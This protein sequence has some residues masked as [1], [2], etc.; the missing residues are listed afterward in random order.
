MATSTTNPLSDRRIQAAHLLRRAGFGGTSQD[1]EQYAAMSHSDAVNKLLNFVPNPQSTFNLQRRM[2][3]VDYI[4]HLD[5]IQTW[6]VDTMLNTPNPLQEK[7]TLFWHGHFTSAYS[8]VDNPI[9]L[10]EQ[11]QLFRAN[12]LGNFKDLV[13]SV[14]R[15]PAMIYYLDGEAN[16]KNAPNE[17]YAR[18]LMELFT[19]GIGNYTETDVRE[20]A[21][22]FTGWGL[23]GRTF[24]FN[25]NNHDNGTKTFMGQTGN[26]NGDDIIDIILKQ[27]ASGKFIVTELWNYFVYPNPDPSVIS[28]LTQIYYNNNYELKPV[29]QAMLT[30]PEFLSAQAYR[31]LVKSPTEFMVGSMKQL[32]VTNIGPQVAKAI[33]AMGQVLFS[34]PTV[35]GWDGG[36]TWFNSAL[37]FERINGANSIAENRGAN[38]YLDP[39]YLLKGATLNSSSDVVNQLLNTMLD[40]QYHPDIQAALQGYFD[41]NNGFSA[42]DLAALSSGNLANGGGKKNATALQVRLRGL[43]HLVMSSP[44]YQLS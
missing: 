19:I 8:K 29:M 39:T 43:L 12:A 25:P 37:F 2:Q 41:P 18:E 11:N 20:A 35:K 9:L 1:I 27:P 7:M 31:A 40:G 34:P 3:E 21:R 42:S 13:K 33:S 22:A 24:Y 16:N 32:D 26:F 14:S 23:K 38:D 15:N 4:P 44:E 5:D 28:N 6:W 10:V 36:I 30:S 17:N